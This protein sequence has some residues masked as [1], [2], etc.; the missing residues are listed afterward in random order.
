MDR[1]WKRHDPKPSMATE[2]YWR[3]VAA[4]L[5][6]TGVQIDRIGSAFEREMC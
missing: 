6:L 4:G 2:P 5:D 3:D 1:H